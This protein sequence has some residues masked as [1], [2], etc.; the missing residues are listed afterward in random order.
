MTPDWMAKLPQETKDRLW[1]E[2]I[3]RDTP[4]EVWAEYQADGVKLWDAVRMEA[5]YAG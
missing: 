2:A 3:L 5:S 4:R 1:R